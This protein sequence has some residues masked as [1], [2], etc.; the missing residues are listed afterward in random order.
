MASFHEQVK[1][2]ISDSK[3]VLCIG[4]DTIINRLPES[5]QNKPQPQLLFNQKIID[6]THDLVC[7]Y[8]PNLAFYLSEGP[9]GLETLQQTIEYSHSKDVPVILDAKFG[10]IGHTADYYAKTA[11]D[12]LNADAVTLNPYMGKESIVP[13]AD[14]SEKTLFILCYTSNFSRIDIQMQK[15]EHA[16]V[17]GEP[18]YQTVAK[19][20]LE[21]NEKGNLGAVVG[22]TAPEEMAEIRMK[23]GN[24]VPILCPGVGIQGGDL[25][26]ILWSGQ[27]EYGSLIVNI[28]RAILYASSADDFAEAARYETEMYVAQ[29]RTFFEQAAEEIGEEHP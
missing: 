17:P 20:I 15:L 13:F 19:K 9:S 22:A 12:Y 25:E 8:K 18:L 26:E 3:S 16:I 28:S 27:A 24:T 6:A 11:F 7:C 21:W 5:I 4:L 2:R 29:M 10:D 23:L 1:S 14:S